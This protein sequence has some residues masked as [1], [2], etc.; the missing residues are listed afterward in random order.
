VTLSS[1]H[2]FII[3]FLQGL[4]FNMAS[5]IDSHEKLKREMLYK[6]YNFDSE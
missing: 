6:S 3:H 4:R 5:L 1:K 2:E